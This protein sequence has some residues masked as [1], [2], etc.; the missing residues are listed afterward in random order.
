MTGHT[1]DESNKTRPNIVFIYC[2]DLGYGDLGCYGSDVIRTPHLDTLAE[3]GVRFSQ[4]YSNSPVCSPSRASLLTGQFPKQTGIDQIVGGERNTPGVCKETPMISEL[5]KQESYRTAIFGK[6]HLGAAP[7]SRPNKRGFDQFCGF[8]SGCV[9]YYS[10]I[11]YHGMPGVQNTHDLWEN[12]EEIWDNGEYLTHIITNRSVDF[13]QD[14]LGAE[15]PFF[16]YAAYNAPHYPM[17]APK[18]VMDRYAHLPWDRQV[19]AAMISAVDDGVGEIIAALKR[20]DQWEN[21]IIFFSSDNGPSSESR[22]WLDG[23]QD[24]YYGGSAGVFRGHKA[25][26]FDGGIREPAI[27]YIPES[28]REGKAW[29]SDALYESREAP[30]SWIKTHHHGRVNHEPVMMADIVPTMLDYAG[31]VYQEAAFA[32]R[33]LKS[34]LEDGASTPHERLYWEYNKQLA[35]RSGDWKLVLNGK[36]DFFKGQ[37]DEVHL[38]NLKNDPSESHNLAAEHPALVEELTADVKRWYEELEAN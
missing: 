30:A 37:P 8:L 19:M 4:W 38:S 24:E 27:L 16:L 35:V 11:F 14:Q 18:D 26:L 9:D 22:N 33:S 29:S 6:W 36:L 1:R 23:R 21:T 34:M 10:H 7:E 3:R 25:S 17:H 12:E 20:T 2:D 32:G 28:L 5:L 13:I 15:Q 31:V